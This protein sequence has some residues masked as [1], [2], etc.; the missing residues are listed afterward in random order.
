MATDHFPSVINYTEI[1]KSCEIRTVE[2]CFKFGRQIYNRCQKVRRWSVPHDFMSVVLP[3]ATPDKSKNA[4][5]HNARAKRR[6]LCDSHELA[7]ANRPDKSQLDLSFSVPRALLYYAIFDQ[8]IFARAF[9]FPGLEL[10]DLFD[11][12]PVCSRL[13]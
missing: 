3:S 12:L 6:D 1:D 9:R 13:N 5:T 7:V 10:N 11:I 2:T 8:N 4:L